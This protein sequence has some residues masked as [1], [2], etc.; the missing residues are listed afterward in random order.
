M[1]SL[2]K[3]VERNF[4]ASEGLNITRF[5]LGDDEI[6]Y[7]LYEPFHPKGSALYDGQLNDTSIRGI[8]R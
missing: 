4:N 3:K 2:P 7:G 5:A 6:D 8:T 1:Q